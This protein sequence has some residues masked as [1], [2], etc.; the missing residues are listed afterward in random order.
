[1][2]GKYF[3]KANVI[4]VGN[5]LRQDVLALEQHWHTK[6]PWFRIDTTIIGIC[7]ADALQAAQ[8][9]GPS[10]A[11]LATM[12]LQ[13]FTM[14]TVADLWNRPYSTRVELC[15]TMASQPGDTPSSVSGQGGHAI[16]TTRALSLVQVMEEHRITRTFQRGK[17]KNLIRRACQMRAEGCKGGQW[18]T[19][20]EHSTCMAKQF[21]AK[22]KY[23]PTKGVFICD[24]LNCMKKH[25]K[26]VHELCQ[27]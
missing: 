27:T 15:S 19:E 10:C 9:Q 12:S 24:N 17:D 25:W 7:V 18:R 5:Q 14:N 16:D 13:D 23:G 3:S 21:P 26:E 2:I 11:N 20:C 22:N 8:Y 4:D 6:D 1:M